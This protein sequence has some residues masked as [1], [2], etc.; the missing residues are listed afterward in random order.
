MLTLFLWVIKKFI[1]FL[2][3][4]ENNFFKKILILI[5]KL[6]NI[7]FNRPTL[8]FFLHYSGMQVVIGLVC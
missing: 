8:R 5:L 4:Y 6:K 3:I 1:S 2:Y 7:L